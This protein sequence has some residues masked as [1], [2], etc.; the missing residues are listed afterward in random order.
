MTRAGRS[1]MTG[2]TDAP[3]LLGVEQLRLLADAVDDNGSYYWRYSIRSRVRNRLQASSRIEA[4]DVEQRGPNLRP[5]AW[6]QRGDERAKRGPV[7][8][9]N[10][11]GLEDTRGG[12]AIGFRQGDLPSQR[13]GLRGT[14]E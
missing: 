13:A 6:R 2:Q 10:P 4:Q 3:T 14:A 12:H 11:L 8:D 7:D 5:S 1:I 9:S